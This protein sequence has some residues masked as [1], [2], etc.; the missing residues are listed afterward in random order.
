LS[1]LQQLTSVPSTISCVSGGSSSAVGVNWRSTCA[2][3][4]A[5]A[6]IAREIVDWDTA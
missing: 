3:R 6:V 2:S 4:G 5:T 1:Q